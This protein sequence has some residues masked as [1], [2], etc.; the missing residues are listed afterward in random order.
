[1]SPASAKRS[2]FADYGFPG[3]RPQSRVAASEV[4]LLNDGIEKAFGDIP[5]GGGPDA[6]VLIGLIEKHLGIEFHQSPV[7]AVQAGV[8]PSPIS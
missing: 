3:G 5:F 8:S 4:V 7:Q 6:G 2:R 1:M